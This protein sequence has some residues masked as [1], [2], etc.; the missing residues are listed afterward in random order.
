[1]PFRSHTENRVFFKDR[2]LECVIRRSLEKPQGELR[3]S[4]L[5]DIHQIDASCRS[6]R[7]LKGIEG[8]TN[9]EV[10][11]LRCNKISDLRVLSL[12]GNSIEDISPLVDLQDI[13]WLALSDN[14]IEDISSLGKL[15][16]LSHLHL[17]RNMIGDIAPIRGLQRLLTLHLNRNSVR[18][19]RTLS[20]LLSLKMIRLARNRICDIRSLLD[21]P[22][23]DEN[24]EVHL[25]D[26]PLDPNT[27]QPY[28][29]TLRSRGV[30]VVL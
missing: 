14:V 22:S 20:E 17:E 27:S 23:L 12:W 11:T 13:E 3:D 1:M 10:L 29:A 16:K 5:L 2:N 24:A 21:N 4:D 25:S 19:I 8:C 15:T 9:L 6:I 18:E 28:V 7:D 26:N 30:S